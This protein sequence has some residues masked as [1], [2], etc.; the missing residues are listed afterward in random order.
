[1]GAIEFLVMIKR[2]PMNCLLDHL[3]S[4]AHLEK[5]FVY[6]NVKVFAMK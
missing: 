4:W 5:M 3:L 1:M 6:S 2:Y